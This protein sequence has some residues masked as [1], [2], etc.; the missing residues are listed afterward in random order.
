MTK[1]NNEDQRKQAGMDSGKKFWDYFEA[2]CWLI[3]IL[4]LLAIVRL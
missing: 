4:S 3:V 2:V 1:Y